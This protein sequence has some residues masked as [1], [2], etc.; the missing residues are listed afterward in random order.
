MT[1]EN[2]EKTSNNKHHESAILVG[3]KNVM[4]YVLACKTLFDKGKNEV[5]IRAR[6][7]LISR[8]VDVAEITRRRF[9]PDLKVKEILIGTSTVQTDKGSELN[10]STIDIVLSR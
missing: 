3:S 7:R 8:A 5:V 2:T 6:G 4:S 1:E 9:M 10:V